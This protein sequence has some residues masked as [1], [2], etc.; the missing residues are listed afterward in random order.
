AARQK[1]VLA[2]LQREAADTVRA[3]GFLDTMPRRYLLDHAT[4]DV[5]QQVRAALSFLEKDRPVGAYAYSSGSDGAP[6]W[7]VVAF[8]PD[9]HGL[10]SIVAGAIASLGHNI[11]GA[12]V[13]TSRASLAMEIF[14]IE[15]IAGGPEEENLERERIAE[16]VRQ[17][18]AGESRI[19]P[20]RGSGAP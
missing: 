2:E 6:F 12:Q 20:R 16:R 7:G 5:V 17:V 3:M 4:A 11:L 10:F 19:T 1:E 9:R 13:Y 15:P 14:Q 18:L 8:S